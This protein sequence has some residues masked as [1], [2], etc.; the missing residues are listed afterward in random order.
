MEFIDG[1]GHRHSIG[2]HVKEWSYEQIE[3]SFKG[4]LDYEKLASQLGKKPKS[5]KPDDLKPSKTVK[6][7]IESKEDE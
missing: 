3:D 5:S 7:I 4:V 2:D 1:S 6:A